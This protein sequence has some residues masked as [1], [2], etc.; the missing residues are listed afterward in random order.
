MPKVPQPK[1]E[2]NKLEGIKPE[3]NGKLMFSNDY[4]D[5]IGLPHPVSKTHPR[6]SMYNRAAQF[7]PFAALVGHD[8]MI[9][10]TARFTDDE[11]DL[12][13]EQ[14]RILNRKMA[15]L[16]ECLPQQPTVTF[17]YFEP[18]RQKTGGAYRSAT[19]IIRKI[20]EYAQ[21]I[22]LTNGISIPI[23]AIFDINGD[24]F[25]EIEF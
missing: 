23:H 9:A 10:E 19:G 16:Q 3:K 13:D 6:M 12:C 20:D 7:A 25:S 2:T 21:I 24:L 18:D 11:E 15:Y 8:V 17:T 5:I 4:S 22:L 1:N 14:N